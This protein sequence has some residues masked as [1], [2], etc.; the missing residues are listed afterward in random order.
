MQTMRKMLK[1]I[2]SPALAMALLI[3][4]LILLIIGVSTRYGFWYRYPSDLSESGF[5]SAFIAVFFVNL[6]LCTITQVN[7]VIKRSKSANSRLEELDISCSMHDDLI[8][9]RVKDCLKGRGFC[10]QVDNYG[11]ITGWKRRLGIWGTV[12]FH[13]GLLAIGIGFFIEAGFAFTGRIALVPGQMFEDR[14]AGYSFVKEGPLHNHNEGEFSIF[15]HN[16]ETKYKETGVFAGG[17]VSL[18]KGGQEVKRK[19]VAA[20][21][22]LNFGLW[23]IHFERFGYFVNTRFKIGEREFPI[24]VGL[25]TMA[26]SDYEKYSEAFNLEGTPYRLDIEFIPD[27]SSYKGPKAK[28]YRP[29]Q[30]AIKLNVRKTEHNGS[31]QI[32]DGVISMDKNIYFDKDAQ[33]TFDGFYSWITFNAKKEPGL[34]VIYAGFIVSLLGVSII[35]LWAPEFLRVKLVREEARAK[36]LIGGWT[37]RYNKEFQSQ[38]AGIKRELTQL[39][40]SKEDK[41]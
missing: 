30:P 41:E 29:V 40:V 10:L 11:E 37:A 16:I 33:I 18:I 35:Y 32:Y 7:R 14:K 4:T 6:L 27:K 25:S 15:L 9:Q 5:I 17:D 13:A 28:T 36:I 34:Y 22:P 23:N 21:K 3:F 12:I 1:Y 20:G 39:S 19:V 8:M 24:A 38:L 26:H 31:K 2:S